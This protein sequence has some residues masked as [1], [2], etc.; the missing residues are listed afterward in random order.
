[1][2]SS[3]V[4][5]VLNVEMDPYRVAQVAWQI[6]SEEDEELDVSAKNVEFG[7]AMDVENGTERDDT[8]EEEVANDS[9]DEE[10]RRISQWTGSMWSRLC[11]EKKKM[12]HLIKSKVRDLNAK[13]AQVIQDFIENEDNVSVE[14]TSN[15]KMVELKGIEKSVEFIEHEDVKFSEVK[16]LDNHD[17]ESTDVE[18]ALDPNLNLVLRIEEAEQKAYNYA[19]ENAV[20]VIKKRR[21]VNGDELDVVY[22]I[23]PVDEDAN[24]EYE[25]KF[26]NYVVK[27][28]DVESANEIDVNSA[29]EIDDSSAKE[30]DENAKRTDVAEVKPFHSKEGLLRLIRLDLGIPDEMELDINYKTTD[31][32][33]YY[34]IKSE[35]LF[36]PPSKKL[37]T[38]VPLNSFKDV[39]EDKGLARSERRI[40]M[41]TSAVSVLMKRVVRKEKEMGS[42]YRIAT[43]NKDDEERE[44]VEGEE[45]KKVMGMSDIHLVSAYVY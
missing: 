4:N 23:S 42:E 24:Y 32:R 34:N 7:F 1:L 35:E 8:V 18:G 44:Y 20:E 15:I 12:V 11:G 5:D 33:I 40:Q 19:N 10:F 36:D 2:Q 21:V 38:N 29:N 22:Q 16:S 31:E 27:K 13:I 39:G 30:T 28:T 14:S 26:E 37:Q 41:P 45:R 17:A 9:I 6:V 25:S 3:N 43:E